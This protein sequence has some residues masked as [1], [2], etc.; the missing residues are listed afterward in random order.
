MGSRTPVLGEARCREVFGDLGYRE[1]GAGRVQADAGWVRANV[2]SCRLSRANGAGEDVLAWC[3]R[4]VK[5]PVEAAFADVEERGVWRLIHSFD[6]LWVPRHQA[7]DPRR[8]LSSHSWGIAFDLNA[9]TNPYGGGAS[10]EN[11]ALNE[12][13]RRYG[14]AWSGDRE[15]AKGDMHWEMADLEAARH[16]VAA[17][18]QP[19]LIIAL[20]HGPSF[21]FHAVPDARLSGETFFVEASSLRPLLGLPASRLPESSQTQREASGKPMMLQDALQSVGLKVLQL[22]DHRNDARDPRYYAF[23][24]SLRRA[25]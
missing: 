12:V 20:R 18:P 11:R 5:E 2:V 14:F 6:G 23:V 21:S 16:V 13:F 24:E 10:V 7:W 4:K 19:R 8:G 25:E 9:P 3:H 22:S 15:N 1:I 17:K